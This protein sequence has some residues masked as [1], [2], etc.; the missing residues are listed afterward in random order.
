[1]P[2]GALNFLPGMGEDVGAHLV[3]HAGVDF[4]AFTGSR[5]VGC[6]IWEAAGKTHPGQANLKKVVCEMGGKNA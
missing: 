6:K 5:A 4:I 2:P 3:A 1:V